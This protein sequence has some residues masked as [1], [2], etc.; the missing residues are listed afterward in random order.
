MS[1]LAGLTHSFGILGDFASVPCEKS[2]C[3][4]VQFLCWPC[5]QRRTVIAPQRGIRSSAFDRI[6]DEDRQ[7]RQKRKRA[8]IEQLMVKR[9]KSQAVLY[10]RWSTCLVPFHVCG[11]YSQRHV[12][13]P[14]SEFTNGATTAVCIEYKPAKRR[15]PPTTT[16]SDQLVHLADLEFLRHGSKYSCSFEDFVLQGWRK[17]AR[18][19]V[20]CN[21]SCQ[22]WVIAKRY[23]VSFG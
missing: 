7:L 19:E 6:S 3:R 1:L 14:H 18:D 22:G 9:A 23:I 15:I 11:L 20:L 17:V 10:D 21:P 8:R 2:W 12:I 5:A 4:Q 13:A 16:H